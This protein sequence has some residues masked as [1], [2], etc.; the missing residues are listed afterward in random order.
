MHRRLQVPGGPRR[1]R[2]PE[3]QA[4]LA[5]PARLPGVSDPL[6]RLGPFQ[7]G[8]C[9]IRVPGCRFVIP[10]RPREATARTPPNRV[11]RADP[12][13][14]T[15]DLSVDISPGVH[16]PCFSLRQERRCRKFPEIG[17]VIVG[18]VIYDPSLKHGFL[19]ET[20]VT[21][22]VRCLIQS[23]SDNRSDTATIGTSA[24]PG[25]DTGGVAFCRRSL[26]VDWFASVARHP[27]P[28]PSRILC[29][30]TGRMTPFSVMM[31]A[32]RAAGVTSK[33]GL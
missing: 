28:S 29:S 9:A 24:A 33:A 22:R 25:D 3:D 20:L 23:A 18:Q 4:A 32:M 10:E 30:L 11:V 19:L 5:R 26:L 13:M 15:A 8:R 7:C 12:M 1:D 21:N 6:E 31:P 17:I 27:R 2:D 16:G 14:A